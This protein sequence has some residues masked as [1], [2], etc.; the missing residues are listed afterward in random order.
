[1]SPESR[2]GDGNVRKTGLIIPY[3][4]AN[5]FSDDLEQVKVQRNPCFAHESIQ[6][7]SGFYDTRIGFEKIIQVV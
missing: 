3:W 5:R 1:L 2:T 7:V 4:E 6:A